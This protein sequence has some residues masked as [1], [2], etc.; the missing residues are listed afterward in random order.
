MTIEHL[1]VGMQLARSFFATRGNHSE[2]HLSEAE[3]AALL[4]IA[5]ERGALAT[6][7][8]AGK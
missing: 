3:L 8:E 1:E 5:A 7:R 2:A 6:L 4:A